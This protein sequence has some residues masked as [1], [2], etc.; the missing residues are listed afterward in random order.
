MICNLSRILKG[1]L[2]IMIEEI[3]NNLRIYNYTFDRES[4][5]IKADNNT[6]YQLKELQEITAFLDVKR[7]NYITDENCN[8]ILK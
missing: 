3:F 8:I 1:W 7:I 6:Y 4:N 5:I 2:T